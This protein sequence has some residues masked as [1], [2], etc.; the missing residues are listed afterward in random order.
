MS[1]Y[2]KEKVLRYPV[3]GDPYRFEEEYKT[4]FSYGKVGKFQVAPTESAFIDYVL[5]YDG[6][7]DG[8]YGKTR[9]LSEKEQA[10]YQAM[11]S[12]IIPGVDMSKVRL[13]EFCWYNATEAPDYYAEVDDPFYAE[14]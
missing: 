9:S 11:W 6:D 5:E 14:I 8:E 3:D 7:S 10:K 4:A 1:T 12:E 13:V 2:V